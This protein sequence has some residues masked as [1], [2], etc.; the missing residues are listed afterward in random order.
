MPIETSRVAPGILY[1]KT[2]GQ[3]NM[4]E[5]GQSRAEGMRLLQE[6]GD[7]EWVLVMDMTEA[8]SPSG[9][10]RDDDMNVDKLRSVTEQN[11]EVKLLGYVVLGANPA[12]KLLMRTY[13]LVFRVDI[14]FETTYN[15]ALTLARKLVDKHRQHVP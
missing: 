5:M 14:Y 2:V 11:K 12:M 13:G 9:P 3:S 15:G 6:A 8:R 4:S 7:E 1:A 10:R